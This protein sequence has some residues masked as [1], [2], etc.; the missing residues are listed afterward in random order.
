MKH[1]PSK[2]LKNISKDSESEA[3][4]GTIQNMFSLNNDEN[5][6]EYK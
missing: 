6:I 2:R 5:I 1:T 3:I 4:V